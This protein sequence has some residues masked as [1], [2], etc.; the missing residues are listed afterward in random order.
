MIIG[1]IYELLSESQP[2]M[3]F[4]EDLLGA[5]L[6]D[7]KYH[8]LVLNTLEG[9]VRQ[10]EWKS[11]DPGLISG[12]LLLSRYGPGNGLV[13]ELSFPQFLCMLTG[14]YGRLRGE[15]LELGPELGL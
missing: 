11:L 9:A 10:R 12:E 8:D 2:A 4:Y 6:A 14:E 1:A 15:V 5:R 13:L 7:V 3:S